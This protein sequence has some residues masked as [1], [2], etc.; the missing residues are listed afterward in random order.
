MVMN[1]SASLPRS[2]LTRRTFQLPRNGS[3]RTTAGSTGV[4]QCLAEHRERSSGRDTT[5]WPVINLPHAIMP[6]RPSPWPTNPRQPLALIEVHRFLGQL[7][8]EA[9]RF[10]DSEGHLADS[11]AIADA[12]AAPFEGALTLIELA[13]LRAAQRHDIEAQ[14]L[15]TEVRGIC[16]PL[17]AR[18]TLDRVANLEARL[19][20]RHPAHTTGLTQRE[21]EVLH[22][23]AEGLTDGDFADRLFI[24][25]RTVTTHVTSI[26][27]KFGV[28]SRA[29]AVAYAARHD[30]LQP[31]PATQST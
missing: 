29:A 19:A 5:N 14:R 17:Q 11:L 23:V 16:E 4:P 3:T 31:S 20:P 10:S 24:S 22:L 9:R 26:L 12:C 15:L 6:M 13:T 1:F 30:L 25:R 8:V 18:P 28:S 2:S 21:C 7:D 27:N